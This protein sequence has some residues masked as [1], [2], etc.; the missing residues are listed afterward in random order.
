MDGELAIYYRDAT[1]LAELIGTRQVS[2]VGVVR[3]HLDR[4]EAVLGRRHRSDAL[5][6]GSGDPNHVFR[7]DVS[8]SNRDRNTTLPT[9]R[10][11]S[12]STGWAAAT[13]SP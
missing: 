10:T 13:K 3:A 6:P 11:S 7:P 12:T 9:S 8:G 5:W 2:S 4:I 1:E